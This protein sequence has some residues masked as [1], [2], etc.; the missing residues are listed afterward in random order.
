MGEHFGIFRP[1]TSWKYIWRSK[2]WKCTYIKHVFLGG[3]LIKPHNTL[4]T[5]N[6]F[7]LLTLTRVTNANMHTS[8]VLRNKSQRIVLLHFR[9]I[10]INVECNISYS[11]CGWLLP[12]CRYIWSEI[13]WF[14]QTVLAKDSRYWTF[15]ETVCWYETWHGRK[16]TQRTRAEKNSNAVENGCARSRTQDDNAHA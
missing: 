7:A 5:S 14:Q 6:E 4:N 15:E 2:P 1:E 13:I 10:V 12:V 3:P 16:G 11:K 9:L 8:C